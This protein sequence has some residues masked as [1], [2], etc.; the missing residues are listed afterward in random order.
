MVIKKTKG[1]VLGLEARCGPRGIDAAAS[2]R[3]PTTRLPLVALWVGKCPP[4]ARMDEGCRYE[5]V[6]GIKI[7]G[8][9]QSILVRPLAG[10]A[11]EA[12]ASERC[13]SRRAWRA[14]KPR[15]SR[16]IM[17]PEPRLCIAH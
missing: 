8:V 6:R 11:C 3:L 2:E 12:I 9:I 7:Q 4:P 5:P 15:R 13:S 10:G 17:R 16:D 1:L 14:W